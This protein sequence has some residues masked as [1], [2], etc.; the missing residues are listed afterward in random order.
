MNILSNHLYK[1][2]INSQE[3]SPASFEDSQNLDSYIMELLETITS[4]DGD[5]EYEFELGSISMKTYVENFVLDME[6]EQTCLTIA[7]RLL[8]KETD[9][10]EKIKHLNKRIQKGILI[11]SYVKMTDSEKK[12]IISKADYNEFLQELTGNVTNGLPLQKKIYKVFVANITKTNEVDLISKLLTYD[13]NT[14]P[15]TYW[16][17]EFLELAVVRNNDENTNRAFKAIE[18]EVLR[19]IDKKHNQDFLYL[20]NATIAYFRGEGEFCIDHYRNEIIGNYQPFDSSLSITDLK[21]KCATLPKKYE[22][23]KKFTKSPKV[24]TKSFKKKLILTDEIDL[25]LKHDIANITK[26]FK[27]YKDVDGE[28]IMIRSKEGYRYAQ[29]IKKQED[30]E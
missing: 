2:D 28:Y 22:F 8:T 14:T 10:Q 15:A 17:K 11:I 25:V 1:I 16:W 23:D 30:N 12:L 29:G 13:R 5:R 9:A 24:V 26:V 3:V 4:E 7:E 20:W 19:P 6:I 27:P 18:K 21:T